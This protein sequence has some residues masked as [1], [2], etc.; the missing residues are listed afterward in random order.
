LANR[1]GYTGPIEVE[2]L[3]PM[4]IGGTT[5]IK[6]GENTGIVI[7]SA[8]PEVPKGPYIVSVTGKANIDGRMVV[9]SA[10]GR[11]PLSLS[12]AN[13]SFPPRH[14]FTRVA[15][16][17]KER[18]P[19]ALT[20]RFE[21]AE[22]VQGLPLNLIVQ[23]QRDPGFD[24][25]ITL[26][27]PTGLPPNMPAPKLPPIAKGQS[28]IKVK[29]DVNPKVPLGEFVVLVG[30]TAKSQGKDVSANSVPARLVVGKPFDLKVEPLA[31]TLKP[32]EKAKLTVT[33]ERKGGYMGPITLEVRKLPA[34]VTAAKATIAMGQTMTEV[35]ITAAAT[36]A[37]AEVK[38]VDI[39]GT[40]TAAGGQQQSSPALVVRVEK[41]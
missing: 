23:A 10:S 11:A 30:G 33:A 17:V 3:G 12:L 35:E 14:L 37:P 13:L 32:G 6:A 5:T 8:K 31:L 36:A 25:P 27:P 7:V 16:A 24:D 28:E 20:T 22:G 40:A 39:L 2:V 4:G 41:K 15:V 1:K 19:F 21:P 38:D 9:R 34:N 26:T 29:L 18:A